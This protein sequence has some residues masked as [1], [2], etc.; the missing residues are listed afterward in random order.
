MS[1]S[2]IKHKLRT[3]TKQASVKEFT[4][5]HSRDTSIAPFHKTR[6]VV[7][8]TAASYHRTH[9]HVQ[10]LLREVVGLHNDAKADQPGTPPI[11]NTLT[12]QGQYKVK[13]KRIITNRPDYK[14]HECLRK[15][16]SEV[17]IT[18]L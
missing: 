4:A 18:S 2:V 12:F 5:L 10:L 1:T 16:I 13:Q 8:D 6:K 14:I 7:G 9:H 17:V 15:N 11:S 3:C